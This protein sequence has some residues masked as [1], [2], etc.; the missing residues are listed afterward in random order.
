MSD[1]IT[2]T[3]AADALGTSPQTVRTL[4]RNGELRGRKQARGKRYVWVPSRKGVDEFLSQYGRLDGRRRT[5]PPPVARLGE[6]ADTVPLAGRADA[7][8]TS[9]PRAPP[10]DAPPITAP[11]ARASARPDPFGYD[12]AHAGP[13]RRPFFLRPRG[14]ATVAVVV[15][16]LPLLL[17]YVSAQILPDALWFD[18][19]GQLDVFRRMAAA[20]AELY[21]AVAGTVSLFVGANLVVAVSRT[22]IARTRAVILA[23]VAASLV[24]ATFFASSAA[25]HWQ[26][27]LLWR[28]RQ[29]FGV[30]DPIFGKDVG[31]FIFSLPFQLVVSGLLL[32]LIAVAAASVALV[33]RAGGALRLRPPHAKHDAQVHLA[34]LAA[35]F[36]LV[37]AWRVRLGQYA[38]ELGQPS[39]ADSDSFA[40]AGYVDVHVRSRGSRGAAD[41]GHRRWLW[42][43]SWPPTWRAGD[44][45]AVRGC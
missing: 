34:A 7:P 20:K 15:L 28:H 13:A 42:P 23:V 4:L 9:V 37:V 31:F 3:Q 30:A 44:T 35:A 36:L 14:R 10:W 26:T 11:R 38:L 2:V 33:Y 40:G 5:R 45:D 19:L 18:E 41:P 21:L 32:W 17:A 24:T 8:S 25:R 12:E 39:P 16:G 22:N 27:F 29:P 1:D 43:A 6:A